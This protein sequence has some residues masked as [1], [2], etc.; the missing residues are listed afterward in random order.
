MSHPSAQHAEPPAGPG[1]LERLIAESPLSRAAAA[2]AARAAAS[3]IPVL[4]EGESGVGKEVFARA[5]HAASPR[6][7]GPF[8]AVN[9]GALPE[10][11]V[12]A[13]LFGHERGAFTGAVEKRAGRFVEAEG[14]TL[15]LDEIGELPLQAQVKLLRALQER[16]VEPVGADR[17][18]RVDIRVLAAT[19]RDL[20]R[21]MAEGRFRE[22][23]Y[24]RLSAFPV[25][26]PPLRARREDIPPL[27]ASLLEEIAAEDGDS[28]PARLSDDA[29]R[30]VVAAPWRGN[31]RELR[32]TLHRAKVLSG[33]GVI[34]PAHL[35]LDVPPDEPA[36]TDPDVLTLAEVEAAHIRFALESCGWRISETAR[37][38]GIGRSTLYRKMSE[39]GLEGK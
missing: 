25:R 23:L 16:E 32:N 36:P 12:E 6:G 26:I 20:R 5:L 24:Y 39:L 14:G 8:V 11:L 4:F 3:D 28:A 21:E 27:A 29:L 15:F 30:V 19:N 1:P 22:D 34:A 31:V 7:G 38:L 9:C 35:V 2:M 18:R 13:I 33:G 37:R 10:A 17:P